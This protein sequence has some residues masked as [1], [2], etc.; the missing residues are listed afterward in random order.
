MIGV[1]GE[2]FA[3]ELVDDVEQLETLPGDGLVKFA[4]GTRT[5]FGC[6]ARSLAAVPSPRLR[7]R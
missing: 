5:W 4:S 7:H 3:G 6:S 2:R 1:D